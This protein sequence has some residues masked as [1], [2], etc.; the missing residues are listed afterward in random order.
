MK[1]TKNILLVGIIAAGIWY[2][3]RQTSRF[4]IGQAGLSALSLKGNGIQIKVRI[5]ILNRSDITATVQNFLGQ[6]Y[7]GTT[8]L[9]LI[10]L[11]NPVQLAARAQASPEL[12]ILINYGSLG[13]ELVSA[14][15]KVLN[16]QLPG[17][18]APDPATPV[19]DPSQFRIRGTLY[20]SGVAVDINQSI[21]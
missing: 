7:Y 15:I 8:P 12:S 3:T 2:L 19:V 1:G 13:I 14:L 9:G 6:L 21:F 16:I 20:V 10:Q 4:D 5:P 18:P 11:T 17:A